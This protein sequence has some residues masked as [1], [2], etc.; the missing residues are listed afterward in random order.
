MRRAYSNI[1]VE[2]KKTTYRQHNEENLAKHFVR[3]TKR[4][5]RERASD[6]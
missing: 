6:I 4:T 2:R 5:Q 3:E 1:K